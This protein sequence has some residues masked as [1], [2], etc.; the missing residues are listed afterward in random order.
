MSDTP[1]NPLPSRIPLIQAPM[2]GVQDWQLAA[3]VSSAGALGSIPCGMLS[4]AQVEAEVR[5]YR[6]ACDKPLNLNFFCHPMP[7][8][9]ADIMERWQ[10]RLAG[11]YDE[12][13]IQPSQGGA[14]RM[15]YDADMA[16]VVEPLKPDVVSFHFGL[17]DAALVEGLKRNNTLII[18]TATTLEE[19]LW[20]QHN[21][22]D[23]GI[24]Q[25][26]EAGGHRGMFLTRD[27]A[28]QSG[29]LALVSLLVSQLSI[30]VIA[31]GG[32][33]SK[34]DIKAALNMGAAA[35]QLGT[36]YLLCDEAK[37]S[38]LHRQQL[39]DLHATTALTNVFSGRPARGIRNR[40]MT[41]LGDICADVAPFPFASAAVTPL[42]QAAEA[43]GRTDFSSLWS[44]QNRRGCQA[45]NAAKLTQAL[46]PDN[47]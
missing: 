47:Q 44:G 12:A 27:L 35:V 41:E 43:Q 39:T 33:G 21:G 1:V 7:T 15:P 29:T 31:A 24:A 34:E 14:L 2:A 38:A 37:T 36:T 4:A 10:T 6:A 3:A 28:T 22:A 17:P 5:A 19:G 45:I 40:L 20:L 46:W 25:G 8:P 42:K 9:S 16:A 11:Y 30:P 13:G 32:I 23:M 26:Y 18:S